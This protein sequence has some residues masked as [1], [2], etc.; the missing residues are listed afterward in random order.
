MTMRASSLTEQEARERAALLDV[1][2][3][4]LAVDLTGLLDGPALRAT[5]TVRFSCAE[6]GASTFL[7]CLAEVE[8][9]VLNG[10]VLA[11]AA[12]PRVPLPH[13][14][15]DNVVVVRSVQT[16]TSSRTG[17]HRSVDASDG[18]VYV[19]TTFEPD[20]APYAWACFDQPDLKAVFAF[21]V[22]VPADW[23]VLSSSGEPVVTEHGA[24]RRWAFP[25]TPR[26][27]TY[28][29]ALNAGPFHLVRREVD[30]HELGLACRRSLAAQLDR[31]ADELFETTRAGLAFFGERFAWPFPQRRYDQVFVP[32]L[33]GAM[34]NWGCVTWSDAFV[35]R[36]E[37]TPGERELRDVVLLH[38]MAHMWFGDLVTMR[39][40]D[41]LW[42]NEA[43][44]EWACHWA[45][46]AVTGH[47]DVWASFLA[48]RK[49][50]GYAADRAPSRHPVRQAA[51][52]VAT[53]A[54]GFDMITYSKGAS[55]LKQLVAWAGE[56]VFVEA[57]R[58][59]FTEHA[60]GNA[61]LEDLM[62]A[63][64]VASGRDTAAW[65][66]AWLDTAGT[67][68][69]TLDGTVLRAQGPDG[70]APRPHRV[71]VGVYVTGERGLVR[72]E[73]LAVETT[74]AATVLPPHEPGELLLV[75][76]DDL[77][78]AVVRP[79]PVGVAALL[80]G[81]AQLPTALAR[82]TAVT[83]AW[84][85]VVLGELPARAFVRCA[86]A[87][88]E[89][90][91][92]AA[93]VEPVL[94]LAVQAASS[95]TP[96]ADRL[97]L[98]GEVADSCV[99]LAR[100]PARRQVA[101]RALARTATGDEQLAD[102]AALTGDDVDLGWRRLER[103]AA[104][105]RLPDGELERLRAADPDPDA[106]LRVLVVRAA[107]PDPHAKA[108]AWSAATSGTQVPLGSMRALGEAFWQPS[109][110]DLL[111]PYAE[112]YLAELA[113]LGRGGMIPAMATSGALFPVVGVDADY[114][115]RLE[116]AARDRA[117]NPVVARTVTE[118][119]DLLRRM[120]A[121]RG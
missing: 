29:P 43:F 101:T 30:G 107:L 62:G 10:R 98:E 115:P 40:W 54:A 26:L 6:P 22:D 46:A 60:W 88:L 48:G 19:W 93:V 57:L 83:T 69:L 119:S 25:D 58:A 47:T 55:V 72:R 85:L 12:G 33:G 113:V 82:A 99:G 41:D 65:T 109:Q 81:A 91:T 13:L 53:A 36:S 7:D 73:R 56:D 61:T 18:S 34:E 21:T 37:P 106:A 4:D 84:Q 108:A 8:E 20:E 63:L 74:G 112:R 120:L 116:A 44:A 100:D 38:E 103:L 94:E 24:A 15:A 51:P 78:F 97:A 118:R 121:A 96:E 86:L 67:D 79:D 2:R 3:Y 23:T 45:A 11:G 66:A 42:L 95:W 68:V 16:A 102:L 70:A 90:E 59:Y 32:E 28:V 111:A 87:V 92:A 39:W 27:S 35:Y 105:G 14:Q 76:D 114:L 31:D 75:N 52:D 50:T 1:E 77:T 110:A 5:S 71:D 104:L 17:V 117:V 49:L 89:V 64:A 80:A 9:V